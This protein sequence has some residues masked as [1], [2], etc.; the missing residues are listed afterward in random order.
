MRRHE[1]NLVARHEQLYRFLPVYSG[2]FDLI[3]QNDGAFGEICGVADHQCPRLSAGERSDIAVQLKALAGET[4]GILDDA[5]PLF[6][7][8]HEPRFCVQIDVFSDSEIHHKIHV[9][10]ELSHQLLPS[11]E[12]FFCGELLAVHKYA[13]SSRCVAVCHPLDVCKQPALSGAGRAD[14]G[15][16]IRGMQLKR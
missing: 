5:F 9:L 13:A 4:V 11:R 10:G 12:A 6:V 15:D 7:R 1:D 3:D 16:D 14:N 8:I 2:V